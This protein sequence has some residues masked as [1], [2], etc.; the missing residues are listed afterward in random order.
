LR[1]E[2]EFLVIGGDY[3]VKVSTE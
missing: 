1:G 2:S 3:P